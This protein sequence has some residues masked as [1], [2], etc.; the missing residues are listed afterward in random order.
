MPNKFHKIYCDYI[1]YSSSYLLKLE[2]LNKL[3]LKL[4][5]N[6]IGKFA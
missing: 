5:T 3:S 6:P 1:L 2:L 4:M